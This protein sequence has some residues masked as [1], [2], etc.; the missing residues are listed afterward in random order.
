MRAVRRAARRIP[1][2]VSLVLGG[3]VAAIAL[4]PGWV[5][6]ITSQA[7]ALASENSRPAF[8]TDDTTTPSPAVD[9]AQ[10]WALCH[11]TG[12][13]AVLHLP[14]R[15]APGGQRAV[16]VYHS[17]GAP[18]AAQASVPVLYFLH[19]L[20][21]T[22]FDLPNNG[23]VPILDETACTL[24]RPFIV[25]APDGNGAS[26]QDTEWADDARGGFS[27]ESFVTGPLIQ[28]VEGMAVRERTNRAI[29]GFS[30]GGYGAVT[31]ALRH[32]DLYGSAA[33]ISGYFKIDDPDDTFGD[34]DAPHDPDQLI[35]RADVVRLML[36]QG[37]QD[38]E[39]V[40]KGELAR[41][42]AL[43]RAAGI[44]PVTLIAP[45]GHDFALVRS[46]L[47]QVLHFLLTDAAS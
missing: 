32:P 5:G 41:Y 47:P 30:M 33:S 18:A 10:A 23:V 38:D 28:A 25:A 20:P 21:G 1:I 8:P 3:S 35:D 7:G 44:S 31:L 46:V 15:G 13:Q 4:I 42:A 2:V 27:V 36:A 11:E 19:G 22:A 12:T 14:D 34:D 17:P 29:F 39:P 26:G 37:A 45:G 16:W 40:V 6:S 24:Q 9:A 43:L